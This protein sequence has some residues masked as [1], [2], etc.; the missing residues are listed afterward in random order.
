VKYRAVGQIHDS[1]PP[2]N[3]QHQKQSNKKTA[4]KNPGEVPV[5]SSGYGGL[6]S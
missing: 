5:Q 6:L 3:A 1:K 4:S 2:I